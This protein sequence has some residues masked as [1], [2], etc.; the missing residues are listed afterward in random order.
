MPTIRELECRLQQIEFDIEEARRRLPAHS[1]K[2]SQMMVLI[3]LEDE[4][5]VIL[6]QLKSMGQDRQKGA[7]CH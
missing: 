5:E 1:V 7:A 2:P 4:R 6:K 3:D